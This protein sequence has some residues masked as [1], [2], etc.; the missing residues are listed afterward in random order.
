MLDT[1]L[2]LQLHLAPLLIQIAQNSGTHADT[3]L[4][5]FMEAAQRRIQSII[6][7]E[8]YGHIF[9]ILVDRQLAHM[10]TYH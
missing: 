1:D 2:S 5:L 3:T 8:I 6:H 7:S 9:G 4:R 10:C